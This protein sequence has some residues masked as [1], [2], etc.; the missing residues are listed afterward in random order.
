[1]AVKKIRRLGRGDPLRPLPL[2]SS[3][4]LP[5]R[6]PIDLDNNPVER[7]IRPVAMTDSFCTSCSSAWKH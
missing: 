6:W 7:A 2:T 3:L 1:M 5:R 4:P